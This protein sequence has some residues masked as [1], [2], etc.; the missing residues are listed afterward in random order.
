MATPIA[1]PSELPV[2]FGLGAAAK[3]DVEVLWPS[4]R[5]DRVAGVAANTMVTVQ[6]EKGAVGTVPLSRK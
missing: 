4:G 5:V 1:A 3:A 2:T 6:E